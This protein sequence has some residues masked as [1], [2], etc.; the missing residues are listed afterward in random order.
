MRH[1]LTALAALLLFSL[2]AAAEAPHPAATPM[3]KALHTLLTGFSRDE[4]SVE[5]LLGRPDSKGKL[6]DSL[7]PALVQAMRA[8]ERETVMRDCGGKYLE[9]MIC[10]LEY[11]PVLCGQ[12]APA[13]FLYRTVGPDRVEMFWPGQPK[14][15]ATYRMAEAGGAWKL[16]GVACTEADSFNLAK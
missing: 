8:A 9:G 7:T 6:P 5:V 4:R 15:A 2:P 11:H 1:P 3:E 14:P 16:D 10:G 13:K 12:D